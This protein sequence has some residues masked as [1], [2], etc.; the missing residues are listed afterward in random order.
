MPQLNVYIPED[1]AEALQR[2][3]DALNLSQ[4]CARALRQ[5][6]Q[7]MEVA[8]QPHGGVNIPRILD[9]L[10]DE[11]QRQS[12]AH[13]DGAADAARWMEE[14][15]TLEEIRRF[16]EWAPQAGYAEL[17][18]QFNSTFTHKLLGKNAPPKGPSHPSRAFL[19]RHEELRRSGMYEPDYWPSYFKGWQQAVA[20]AWSEIKDQL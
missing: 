5:E 20:A 17:L 7:K 4:I 2:H 14:E 10:R 13:R 12:A 9:R 15:A 8:A 18:S 6:V 3:R 11:Q 1:L 19:Q 16:A